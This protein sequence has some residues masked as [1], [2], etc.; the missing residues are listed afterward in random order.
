MQAET[1][2]RVGGERWGQGPAGSN[3]SAAWPEACCVDVC[4]C[5][6]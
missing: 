1:Q 4:I 2:G 5:V 3:N 6:L